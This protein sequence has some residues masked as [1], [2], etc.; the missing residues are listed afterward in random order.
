MERPENHEGMVKTHAVRVLRERRMSESD[1]DDLMQEGM[2]AV[3]SLCQTFDPKAGC[4]F[5]TY[6]YDAVRSRM[7]KY[8]DR[9]DAARNVRPKDVRPRSRFE[10]RTAESFD[11]SY[12]HTGADTFEMDR[13]ENR[14]MFEMVMGVLPQLG[15]R[16]AQIVR[17]YYGL[18]TGEP[19]TMRQVGQKHGV[20]QQRASQ[21]VR[22]SLSLLR[23]FTEAA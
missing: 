18:D 15:D 14:E 3:T 19:M 6:A 2:L 11:Q 23:E 17:D 1:F 4:T 7:L 16:N 10:N 8:S 20:C 9:C 13:V 5:S 12:H 21:I 22:R